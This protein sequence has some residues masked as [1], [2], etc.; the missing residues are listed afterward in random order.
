MSITPMQTFLFNIKL[1]SSSCTVYICH[2][3]RSRLQESSTTILIFSPRFENNETIKCSSRNNT[4]VSTPG[5]VLEI[6]FNICLLSYPVDKVICPLVFTLF[7]ILSPGLEKHYT[8]KFIS[9]IFPGMLIYMVCLNV[10]FFFPQSR[11][12]GPYY[13]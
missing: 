4:Y 5:I 10:L 1:N 9:D 7:R 8:F 3:L 2:T 6:H 13:C 11:E 12:Q